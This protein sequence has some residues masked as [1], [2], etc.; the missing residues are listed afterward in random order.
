MLASG[1]NSPIS[2]AILETAT[3]E[4]ALISDACKNPSREVAI[5]SFLKSSV[6]ACAILCK[7]PSI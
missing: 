5:K 7:I 2:F 6:L 3:N 4:Y 1:F